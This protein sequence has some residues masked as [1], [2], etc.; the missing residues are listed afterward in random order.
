MSIAADLKVDS[1]KRDRRQ[2]VQTIKLLPEQLCA[3]CP[4]CVLKEHGV[5]GTLGVSS[6]SKHS[7]GPLQ[8][9]QVG[10]SPWGEVLA[11]ISDSFLHAFG[12]Y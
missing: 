9:W 8:L 5:G 12:S 10:G 4:G 6:E 3:R 7:H 11:G 2:S 1:Q